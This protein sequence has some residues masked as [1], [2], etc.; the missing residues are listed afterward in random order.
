MDLDLFLVRLALGFY[1]AGVVIAF[2]A[3]LARR[4]GLL[5]WLPV[6]AASGL[7]LSLISFARAWWITGSMP[8]E[9]TA[10]RIFFL[11]WAAVL[12]YLV[13]VFLYRLEILGVII[14]PLVLV[15]ELVSN[16]LPR[17]AVAVPERMQP[18]LLFFHVGVATL[19]VAA[20]FLGFG[21]SILYLIQERGLKAKRPARFLLRLPSLAGCDQVGHL[22]L[23]WGFPLLTLALVTGAVWSANVRDLYWLSSGRETFAL[24]AWS[25]LAV[26]LFARLVR[27]WRGPKA[28]YLTIV[29]FMA[30]LA[31]ML[32]LSIP[33]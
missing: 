22:A 8:L 7:V 17:D 23:L 31:R 28:A 16:Y 9:N 32:G 18:G 13:A 5:R 3:V 33:L 15:L 6:V 25:I 2:T 21:A 30:V 14:L 26:I 1:L 20:M 10:E 4:Q 19:G 12:G 29:A 11:G 27:G 24:L